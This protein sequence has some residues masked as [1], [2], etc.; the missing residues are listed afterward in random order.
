M[1]VLYDGYIYAIQRNGGINRYF[2]SLIAR[3]PAS[4]EATVT[5]PFRRRQPLP[6]RDNLQLIR[7]WSP[8][9]RTF[10]PFYRG[11]KRRI[12]ALDRSGCFDLAHPTYHDLLSGGRVADYPLPTVLTVHDM[13]PELFQSEHPRIRESLPRKRAAIERADAIICVSR[14]TK[15]DLLRLLEVPE[16][17]VHVIP[18]ASEVDRSLVNGAPPLAT[19]PYLLFVGGRGGYKNFS[20]LLQA[21]EQVVGER[22]ELGLAVVGPPFDEAETAELEARGLGGRVTLASDLDDVR[23]ATLYAH[24]EALV[25]PSL[26]E[27]FGIPPLEAMACGTAVIAGNR[28]SVP[29]VVGDAAAMIDPESVTELRDAILKLADPESRQRLVEAGLARA[30]GFSWRRTADATLEV[31]R[32]VA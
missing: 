11:F 26:Y 1:K 16:E 6:H 10:G 5:A 13:I 17:K 2:N 20:G 23:L 8:G 19:P 15:A 22:P 30:A 27:G 14:N 18:L 28:S 31:Y 25:Y 32:A 9:G 21:L 4:V 7:P 3:M 29:E 12:R 24:A